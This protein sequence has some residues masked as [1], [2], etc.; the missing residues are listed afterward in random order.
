MSR[1]KQPSIVE[2]LANMAPGPNDP[3]AAVAVAEPPF[4]TIAGEPQNDAPADPQ[5]PPHREPD[6]EAD[7]D[8]VQA[9]RPAVPPLEPLWEVTCPGEPLPKATVPALTEELA[10]ERYRQ[11]FL[12]RRPK[13]VARRLS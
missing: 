1:R 9:D 10:I 2:A 12:I 4:E 11:R 8:S 5:T 6:P 13:V 7:A 3:D